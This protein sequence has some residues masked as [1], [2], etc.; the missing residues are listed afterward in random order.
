MC[1]FSSCGSTVHK[2]DVKMPI[3]KIHF[4]PLCVCRASWALALPSKSKSNTGRSILRRGVTLQH[5]SSRFALKN[6][7]VSSHICFSFFCPKQNTNSFL[8]S[9]NPRVLGDFTLQTFLVRTWCAPGIF[10]SR[11]YRFQCTG[12]LQTSPLGIGQHFNKQSNKMSL[13]YSLVTFKTAKHKKKSRIIMHRTLVESEAAATLRTT[14]FISQWMLEL[15]AGT[16][17]RLKNAV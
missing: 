16:R 10:M 9:P 17:E 13:R 3:K 2:E 6:R 11:L 7:F 14:Y 5:A 1:S 8:T 4:W 12:E 15:L